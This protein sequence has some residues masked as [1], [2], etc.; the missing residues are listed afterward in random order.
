V[1]VGGDEWTTLKESVAAE[2]RRPLT[3]ILGLALA[4]KHTDAASPDG[5]DM[6]KQLATSAR[7][8][9]RLVGQMMEL[10]KIADG[11]LAPN[12]RRTNLEAL[13]RRVIEESQDLAKRHVEVEA[14]RVAIRVDPHLAEQMIDALLANA[15]KRTAPGNP[16][17]VK[18]AS[19]LGGVVI[20]VEDT[21]SELPPGLRSAM[22][23]AATDEDP[24]GSRSKPTGATGLSLLERLAEIHGGR[25]WVEERQGGGASFRVLLSDDGAGAPV[26]EPPRGSAVA[27]V[28]EADEAS[29][30]ATA[31]ARAE[32][33]EVD[34]RE[35]PDV[36]ALREVLTG[37]S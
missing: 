17:W 37:Q 34:A 20:A 8:L 25:A 31:E 26:A 30:D 16:V 21:G 23:A 32:D 5:K 13:V 27:L 14:E 22:L 1:I 7:K 9:D 29:A 2:V 11:T 18:V 12:R 3:S 10:D 35:L 33:A 28:P 15:V 4:L 19:D 24:D 6:I 36:E